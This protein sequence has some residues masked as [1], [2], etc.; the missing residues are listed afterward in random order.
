M[1]KN[2]QI[3]QIT[4]VNLFVANF[5]KLTRPGLI[6]LAFF[7]CFNSFAS[8][9]RIGIV[10]TGFCPDLL[11]NKHKNVTIYPEYDATY[12]VKTDCK[13]LNSKH[14]RYHG[15]WVLQT[16]LDSIDKEVVIDIWPVI[17]FDFEANQKEQYWISALSYLEKKRPDIILSAAGL[18]HQKLSSK[19]KLI[20]AKYFLASGRIGGPI[21]PKTK[22]FPHELAPQENIYIIGSYFPPLN[23]DDYVYDDKLLYIDKINYF[24]SQGPIGA[25]FVGTS[26][27]VAEALGRAINLCGDKMN[28]NDVEL[29][30][31]LKEHQKI[32]KTGFTNKEMPTY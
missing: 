31:C 17:I 8:Q 3:G 4:I 1:L 19:L 27:S 22:L 15:Q 5:L 2:Q 30:L 25:E 20:D 28:K 9:I 16:L 14:R 24:F 32:I 12:S 23:K 10:D 11:N 26:R 7:F 6:I 13:K 29:K 21:K 18:P